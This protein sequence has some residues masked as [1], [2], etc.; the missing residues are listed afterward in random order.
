MA[1][2][3]APSIFACR[4]VRKIQPTVPVAVHAALFSKWELT[5]CKAFPVLSSDPPTSS[6]SSTGAHTED[7]GQMVPLATWWSLA[8]YIQ[9]S[10]RLPYVGHPAGSS[11]VEP[12]VPPS[13][14]YPANY[15]SCVV[16]HPVCEASCLTVHTVHSVH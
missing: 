3:R 8:S 10:L 7:R 12:Q 11:S 6:Q 14:G 13:T 15:S 4:T 16:S 5:A 1:L 9:W 2:R